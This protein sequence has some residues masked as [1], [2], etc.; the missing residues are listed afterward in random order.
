M[1]AKLCK[2]KNTYTDDCPT[3]NCH[4]PDYNRQGVGSLIS[5]GVSVV[6]N[7]SS[8]RTISNDRAGLPD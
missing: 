1:K 5:N 8:E 2:C 6:D 7:T 4:Y 3:N